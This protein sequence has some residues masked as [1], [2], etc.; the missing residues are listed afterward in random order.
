LRKETNIVE[1]FDYLI[2]K[3]HFSII[4]Y[5]Y[6]FIKGHGDQPLN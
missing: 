2:C 4:Y 5:F 3:Q 1:P 6:I